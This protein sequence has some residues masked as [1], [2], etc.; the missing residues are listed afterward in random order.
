MP[1]WAK[2]SCRQSLQRAVVALHTLDLWQLLLRLIGV[3]SEVLDDAIFVMLWNLCALVV[4]TWC[5]R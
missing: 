5:W 4:W 3:D 1:H 2:W